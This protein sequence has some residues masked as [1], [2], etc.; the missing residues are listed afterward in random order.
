M[1]F[2]DIS[3]LSSQDRDDNKLCKICS[4]NMSLSSQRQTTMFNVFKTTRCCKKHIPVHIQ[5]ALKFSSLINTDYKYDT[6]TYEKDDTMPLYCLDCAQRCFFCN[7]QH[8]LGHQHVK[9]HIC[10]QCKKHWCYF[11]SKC[12]A[13]HMSDLCEDCI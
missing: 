1:E 10:P 8:T 5:C 4:K 13:E 9:V 3:S 12:K 7:K 11:Y 2:H 6:A